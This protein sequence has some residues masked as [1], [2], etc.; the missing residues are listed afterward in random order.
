MGD[1]YR[2]Q[3]SFENALMIYKKNNKNNKIQEVE[4]MISLISMM[5]ILI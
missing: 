1:F 3:N 4:N 5:K 2:S